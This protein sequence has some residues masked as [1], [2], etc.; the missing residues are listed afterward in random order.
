MIAAAEQQDSASR[1]VVVLH[2]FVLR[3]CAAGALPCNTTDRHVGNQSG[4]DAEE[5]DQKFDASHRT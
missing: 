5:L 2:C 4:Q 1:T 3:V